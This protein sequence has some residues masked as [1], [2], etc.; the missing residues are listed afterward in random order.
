MIF[1][2]ES[3]NFYSQGY[4]KIHGVCGKLNQAC[5]LRLEAGFLGLLMEGEVLEEYHKVLNNM[6]C[7]QEITFCPRDTGKS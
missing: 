3:P 4:L 5:I 7:F 2:R 6:A 1:V